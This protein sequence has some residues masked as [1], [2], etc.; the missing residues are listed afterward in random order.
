MLG[1]QE[2]LED[3]IER[4]LIQE[5]KKKKWFIFGCPESW[6]LQGLLPRCLEPGLLCAGLFVGGGGARDSRARRLQEMGCRGLVAL[7]YVGSSRPGIEP[8]MGRRIL[9]Y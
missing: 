7:Q 3:N 9:Y 6:F 8:C 1:T 5:I 2:S 4:V